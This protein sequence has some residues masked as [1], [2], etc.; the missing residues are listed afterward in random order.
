[1]NHPSKTFKA[2]QCSAVE[3]PC[4]MKS[5]PRNAAVSRQLQN[6]LNRVIGQLNGI[7]KMLDDG[8][9]CGDI[10]I[11]VAASE[12][13]LENFGQILLKDHMET[14]VVEEIR[15]GNLQVVDEAIDL[16]QRL[17]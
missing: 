3:R 10:L 4:H 5:T 17:K 15:K 6:R 16:I 8:R 1:M 7:K 2:P 11:Q 12:K 9:Y 14:C 13:A